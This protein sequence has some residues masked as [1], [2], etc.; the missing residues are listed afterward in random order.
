MDKIKIALEELS[1]SGLSDVEIGKEIGAPASIVQRLR[2]G[3]HKATSYERG[4]KIMEYHK[5]VFETVA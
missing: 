5:R 1:G 2:Q 3:I 4:I